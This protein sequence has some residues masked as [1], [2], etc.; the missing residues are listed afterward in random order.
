MKE[1]WY[2]FFYQLFWIFLKVF[3]NCDNTALHCG[4]I[5]TNRTNKEKCIRE[6]EIS[7]LN[8]TA[9]SAV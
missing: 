3:M 9:V 7:A 6:T 4:T 1:K 5:L 2:F 8:S